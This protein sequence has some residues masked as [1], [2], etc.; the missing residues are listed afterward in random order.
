MIS[1][2]V[3]NLFDEFGGEGESFWRSEFKTVYFSSLSFSFFFFSCFY[4]LFLVQ[5]NGVCLKGIEECR[6]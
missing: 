2:N 5:E 3:S 4:S 1:A 6:S